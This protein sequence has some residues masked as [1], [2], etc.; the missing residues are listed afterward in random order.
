MWVTLKLTFCTRKYLIYAVVKKYHKFQDQT[1]VY[2]F[3][4]VLNNNIF[5]IKLKTRLRAYLA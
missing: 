1:Q 4:L 3:F 5:F 2:V